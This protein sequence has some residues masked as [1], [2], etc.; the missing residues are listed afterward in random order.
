[1]NSTIEEED[2]I[3]S[4]NEDTISENEIKIARNSSMIHQSFSSTIFL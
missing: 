3:F 1:M 2:E 4:D